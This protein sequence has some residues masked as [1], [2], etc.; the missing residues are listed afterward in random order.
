MDVEG[1]AVTLEIGNV[2]DGAVINAGV[3]TGVATGWLV[4]CAAATWCWLFEYHH[5]ATPAATTPP[6]RMNFVLFFMDQLSE[7]EKSFRAVLRTVAPAAISAAVVAADDDGGAVLITVV[8]A[9]LFICD[10]MNTPAS[11]PPPSSSKVVVSTSPT[12]LRLLFAMLNFFW[13]KHTD[14]VLVLFRIVYCDLSYGKQVVPQ[15]GISGR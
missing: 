12:L 3:A 11:T 7:S 13:L 8:V 2:G 1:V 15:L 5:N 6:A 9:G 4:I 10:K 14:Q